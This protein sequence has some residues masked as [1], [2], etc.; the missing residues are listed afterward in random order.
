[1]HWADVL[2]RLRALVSR[3]Q[4][5]EDLQDEL[6]FHLEMQARKNQ[7]GELTSEEARRQA[8]LQFGSIER[9]T[10]ECRDLVAQRNKEIGIRMALGASTPAVAALVLKQSAKLATVGIGIGAVI[11]ILFR[12]FW[13]SRSKST[14]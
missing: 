12:G 4:M 13:C 5:D 2:L 10:D 3:R 9:A 8:R 1:M 7:P 6:H 11:T 14:L